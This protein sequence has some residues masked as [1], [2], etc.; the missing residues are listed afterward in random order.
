MS[1]AEGISAAVKYAELDIAG[2]QRP[3][4]ECHREP[5]GWLR[6]GR[7]PAGG[8]WRCRIAHRQE[9]RDSGRRN[10]ASPLGSEEHLQ[11]I[12]GERNPHWKNDAAGYRSIH[13]CVNRI[14][15]KT[16]VCSQCGRKGV[17]TVWANISREYRRDPDDYCEKCYICNRSG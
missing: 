17:R 15:A 10:G 6:D 11:K 9:V 2:E 7:T 4:C 14:K 13:L 5:M 12:S 16:G 1:V 3:R 8:S